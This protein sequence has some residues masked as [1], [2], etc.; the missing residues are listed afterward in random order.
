MPAGRT[1]VVLES[2]QSSPG[3]ETLF[4]DVD[5]SV[6]GP[7]R[8]ALTGRNGAGKTT[9]LRIICGELPPDAG[10]VVRAEGRV[11]YLSQRLDLF[12]L[13][14][15]VADNLAAFAPSLSE[16]RR[17]HLLARFLF[18]GN[19]YTAAGGRAVRR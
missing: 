5:L 7:E 1:V 2:V 15:T 13:E 8:V 11:A 4:A 17:M 18:R 10:R 16:T 19:R 14:R 9:L 6:R 12:D 3:G